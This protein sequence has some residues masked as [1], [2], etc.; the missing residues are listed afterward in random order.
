MEK[1]GLMKIVLGAVIL[2]VAVVPIMTTCFNGLFVSGDV[3][4]YTNDDDG[5]ETY[6]HIGNR[7][8][9]ITEYAKKKG[10]DSWHVRIGYGCT[11]YELKKGDNIIETWGEDPTDHGYNMENA[12][13]YYSLPLIFFYN[14][15]DNGAYVFYRNAQMYGIMER[16]YWCLDIIPDGNGITVKGYLMGD[17]TEPDT[18]TYPDL[19]GLYF[20][21]DGGDYMLGCLNSMTYTDEKQLSVVIHGAGLSSTDIIIHDGKV[22]LNNT[23]DAIEIYDLD[24][25]YVTEDLEGGGKKLTAIKISYKY[26]DPLYAETFP[27]SYTQDSRFDAVMPYTVYTVDG[28]VTPMMSILLTVIPIVILAGIVFWLIA[29]MKLS[30]GAE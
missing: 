14:N 16:G 5:N 24:V 18:E 3:T 10:A 1:E 17:E 27:V 25:E 23:S 29:R 8:I 22:T 28:Y 13:D 11:W 21:K 2:V 19:D 26:D 15:G 6:G 7:G 12:T 30:G 4:T 9:E 20:A